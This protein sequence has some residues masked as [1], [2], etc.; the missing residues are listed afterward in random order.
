MS[1]LSIS[2]GIEPPDYQASVVTTTPPSRYLP[3][4]R[5]K[6]FW[7]LGT[8]GYTYLK[9][10]GRKGILLSRYGVKSKN[11]SPS[12]VVP[13]PNNNKTYLGKENKGTYTFLKPI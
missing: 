10:K 3:T 5:Y 1:G 13:I 2:A 8:V 6:I 12:Y 11:T 7:Y 9:K 4:V